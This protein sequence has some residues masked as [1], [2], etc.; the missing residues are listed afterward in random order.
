LIFHFAKQDDLFLLT[1]LKMTG[2]FFFVDKGAISGGGHSQSPADMR[3]LPGRHTRVAFYFTDGSSLYFNDMR[4][5]GY[6]KIARAEEVTKAKARFGQEPIAD[7]F[8]IELFATTLK[9]RRTP[10]K[11]ALLDQTFI[12]GLG[13]IYVDEAL[14]AAA[15]RP[16]R[17]A[18]KVTKQEAQAIAQA[19]GSV[20]K[21]AI[22]VGGT[23][24]QHF[25]DTDGEKGNYIDYLQVFG[26]QN[27]PCPKC[28]SL[29]KKI[30]VAGRGTHFCPN[31]QK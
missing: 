16:T 7:D 10:I 13:N 23:T 22:T 3:E 26:K 25:A 5:F 8:D 6:V 28:Q 15:V 1:H 31:C 24:F 12:A 27:T 17:R 30:R 11:A 21:K 19:S 9:R 4:M 18:D 2:Q 29:I 14:F 20:M